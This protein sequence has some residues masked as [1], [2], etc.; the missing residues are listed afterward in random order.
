MASHSQ[1]ITAPSFP[2][3][4][5]RN[6]L[7]DRWFYFAMAL[8][9]AGVIVAG[10][11]RTVD[12]HLFHAAP[13]RPFLLWVHA[14]AFTGWIAFYILQS[15]LVRTRNVRIH[16]T[17]GW[18]GVALGAFMI[19]LGFI[20]AVIMGRFD[21][22]TLHQPGVEEF[23]IVPYYD[24]VVFGIAL[25][26]AI[27][28][29]R[30]PDLHRPLLLIATA[31]LLDAGFGRFDYIFNHDL[32]YLCIDGLVLLGILRDL[33]V[34]RRIHKVYLVALPALAVSEALVIHIFRSASPW[35]VH[36]AHTL[37]G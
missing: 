31:I 17:L 28:W 18:F 30:K 14:A 5:G 9:M 13:P 26:L 27:L 11:C 29:R 4:T 16:R 22:F 15:G 37:I 20:V 21:K 2:A 23:L 8:L 33:A 10:F 12:P 25:A 7:I 3:L 32:S 35:W 36:I 1:Q 24:M 6:G 34:T 19:P